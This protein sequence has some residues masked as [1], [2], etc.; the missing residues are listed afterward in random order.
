MDRTRII[1]ASS[2][3][4]GTGRL[5]GWTLAEASSGAVIGAA[6]FG[7]VVVYDYHGAAVAVKEL[8]AGAD[9]ASIGAFANLRVF[10]SCRP[11]PPLPLTGRRSLGLLSV[12]FVF[13]NCDRAA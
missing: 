3:K 2:A 7:Q 1:A 13:Y 9:K 11:R 10:F 5:L 8:K 6:A 4:D 12:Y